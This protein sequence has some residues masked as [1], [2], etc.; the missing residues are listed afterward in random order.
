V[1]APGEEEVRDADL[2]AGDADLVAG[3]VVEVLGEWRRITAI[4]PYAGPLTGVVF[5]VAEVVGGAEIPLCIGQWTMRR[6]A[7]EP[8]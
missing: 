2:V 6:R 3:D 7:S 4:R 1:S 8:A 5:A